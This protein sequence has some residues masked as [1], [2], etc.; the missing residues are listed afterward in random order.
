MRRDLTWGVQFAPGGTWPGLLANA[1]CE[2]HGHGCCAQSAAKPVL[3]VEKPRLREDMLHALTTAALA[4][5][6]RAFTKHP[7]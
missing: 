5:S 3:S 1:R 2:R 6:A 7:R 4:G